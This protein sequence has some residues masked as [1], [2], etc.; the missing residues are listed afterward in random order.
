MILFTLNKK[1]I[2]LQYKFEYLRYKIKWRNNTNDTLLDFVEWKRVM[3]GDVF[4]PTGRAT[5]PSCLPISKI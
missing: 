5:L 2:E 1:M 4:K 3:T